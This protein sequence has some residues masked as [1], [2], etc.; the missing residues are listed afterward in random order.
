MRQILIALALLVLPAT[1]QAVEP[2]APA[3]VQD[4]TGRD[5]AAEKSAGA[6]V[7]RESCASCHDAGLGRAPQ[8]FVL[9]DMTPQA[10]HTALTGGAMRLQGEALSA[11]QKTEVAEY[12]TG[13]KLVANT[14]AAT[15]NMCQGKAARFDLG[16]PPAFAG[17]GL[18]PASTHSIPAKVS[19][20]TKQ[21]LPRLRLKWAFGFPDSQRARSQPALAGGAILVGN[22][23]GT[24]YAL[25]RETGCVRWAFAAQAEV[26][27]G[28]VVSPWRKGDRRA[29]PLVHFGDTMGNVYGVNLLDGTLAWKDRADRHPATVITGTPTLWKGVL[30]VPT[31]SVEEAFATSPAYACCNFRGAIV[32][33]D[34]RT[35]QVMWR[36]FQVGEPQPQGTSRD[37]TEKFGP[38][39]VAVWNSP[40]VDRKRGR[41]V[42]ATGDNYSMPATG[43][44]D[45]VVT[46]DL[47]TGVPRWHYQ[48]T[49]GDVWTVACVTKTA[50]ACPDEAAPDFDFGAGVV[51]A[52]GKDGRE[53]ILAGQKSGIVHA[54]DPDSGRKVWQTRVGRGGAGGGV[55]F[56]MAAADG[57]LFVPITDHFQ[58]G[59]PDFPASPGLYALDVATG[60]FVWKLPSPTTSCATMV[61][62]PG[63]GGSV[64]ATAGMVLAGDDQGVLRI[65]DAALGKVLW[66]DQTAR[67]FATVNGVAAKGGAIS[68]GVAPLA[69]KGNVIVPS[70]YGYASKLPGN[71][72]LVYGVD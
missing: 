58:F 43:Y 41:L 9:Q 7:Y 62:H 1:L 60:K 68:G 22:H 39:G 12:I 42:F 25:D 11:A 15:L 56:G 2:L 72:L 51:L 26:R 61:C 18:D 44:S 67:A 49:E 27:T 6:A 46:M 17:W 50:D 19:Q 40:L 13:R 16:E 63:Y 31:S 70:G 32:A 54:L 38:S 53:L 45:A 65:V 37:G 36:N 69:Y 28:I 4:W 47:G 8:R 48:A 23:N 30:Y 33:Y 71:V 34:A 55:H 21:D 52:K 66:E 5:P 29:R 57:L 20:L 64:T 59:P 35:G 14:A 24:V 10:V 3:E